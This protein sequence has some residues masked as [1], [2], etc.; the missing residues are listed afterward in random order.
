MSDPAARAIADDAFV[1]LAQGLRPFVEERFRSAYG[2]DWK[3]RAG[4]ASAVGIGS[5]IRS[6][7]DPKVLLEEVGNRPLWDQVFRRGLVESADANATS[8]L[9]ADLR[10]LRN[11]LYHHDRFEVSEAWRV[12]D[13]TRRLLRAFDGLDIDLGARLDALEVRAGVLAAADRLPDLERLRAEYRESLLAAT[14]YLEQGGISPSVGTRVVRVRAGDVYIAPHLTE[15]S[16]RE[17]APGASNWML[18]GEELRSL[19]WDQRHAL[20]KEQQ[21]SYDLILADAKNLGAYLSAAR[22]A[23]AESADDGH[24][25]ALGFPRVAIV[26]PP[27]SGKSSYLRFVAR[28]AVLGTLDALRGRTPILV[29]VSRLAEALAA[30]PGL[31]LRRFILHR[32]TERFGELFGLELELGRALV[33]LDGI[34]EVASEADRSRVLGAIATFCGDHPSINVIVTSR[35]VGFRPTGGGP[36]VSRLPSVGVRGGVGSRSGRDRVVPAGGAASRIGPRVYA[37]ASP[38]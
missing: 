15:E 13:S 33:L 38:C 20:R 10:R 6:L 24:T 23:R 28:G 22:D 3:Q 19:T 25:F 2:D 5:A 27:G 37:R 34:D 17:P 31:G 7:D 14:T 36:S 16:P 18:E 30:E 21:R 32:H 29:R 11:D 26:G 12:V 35:P 4:F 1:V 8:G 9:V